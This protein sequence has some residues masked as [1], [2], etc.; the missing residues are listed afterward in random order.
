VVDPNHFLPR[1]Y[2]WNAALEQ[3]LGKADVFSITY[4]A[5]GGRKLMRQDLYDA[6][7]P[8]FTGEF[9]LMRNGATPD[10][11]ALQA[12]Y[13]HRLSQGLQTL[14]SYTWSHSI[15]D[16]SSD[17]Y[18]V[19][20]PP[21]TAS[22]PGDRGSSDYDIRDTFAGAVSYDVPGPGSGLVKMILGNWSTVS[23]IYSRSAPTVN[24][25]TGQNPF[26]GTFLSANYSA[27]IWFPECRTISMT[28]TNPAARS[29]TQRHSA[30]LPRATEIS[31]A[32]PFADSE[33]R[34]SI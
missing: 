34:N 15:D 32:M 4:V 13:R 29:T 21:G 5:A 7:N 31:D 27:Q 10:Y 33:R 23:I 12:Q 20:V 14:L 28:R 11:D 22:S 16:V 2:E 9:D 3:A 1:T 6:P 30:S 25:V 8:E 18:F 17:V 24:V 26:P 19:S